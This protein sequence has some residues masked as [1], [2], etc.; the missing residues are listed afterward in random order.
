MQRVIIMGYSVTSKESAEQIFGSQVYIIQRMF[1]KGPSGRV[2]DWV[3]RDI[4]HKCPTQ[5]STA[6][7]L[8]L[9]LFRVMEVL[10]VTGSDLG[11]AATLRI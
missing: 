9:S 6:F 1:E 8:H 5:R 2:Q 7:P 4:T 10:K 11:F 3:L